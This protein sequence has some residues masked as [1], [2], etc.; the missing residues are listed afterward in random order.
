MSMENISHNVAAKVFKFSS[1]SSDPPEHS[2]TYVWS[3]IQL[4]TAQDV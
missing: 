1:I 4:I 3:V 2:E